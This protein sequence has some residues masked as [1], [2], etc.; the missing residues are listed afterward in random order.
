MHTEHSPVEWRGKPV[1]VPPMTA[2]DW[3]KLKEAGALPDSIDD[4]SC[5]ALLDRIFEN[6]KLRQQE[7]ND[8]PGSKELKLALRKLKNAEIGQPLDCFLVD[9]RLEKHVRLS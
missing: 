9:R 8:S 1:F 7:L 3:T 5:R 2:D 6:A 4:I